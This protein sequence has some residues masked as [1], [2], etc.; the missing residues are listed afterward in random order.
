M[1]ANAI[2]A[3]ISYMLVSS[4]TPGPGN[5]LTL[6]TMSNYGWSK[7]KNLFFGICTGY[8][9]VQILCALAIYGLNTYFSPALEILKY[10]GA[11]YLVWMAVHIIRSKPD[12]LAEQKKPSFFTGFLLQFVNIK[13]YLY[14]M[15]ALSGYIVPYYDGFLPLLIAEIIIATVGSAASL[16]WALM[17]IKIQKI[18]SKHYLA[19]NIILAVLLVYCAGS[20]VFE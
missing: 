1:P 2:G 15:T 13:I 19:V 20:M 17:G 12:H 7:G 8:Y 3:L 5:I 16:T 6:N 18:Y 4:F 10:I 9:C 11:A 14:G